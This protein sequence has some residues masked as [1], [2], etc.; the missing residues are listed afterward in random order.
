MIKKLLIITFTIVSC[1]GLAQ[2]NKFR[3]KEYSIFDSKTHKVIQENTDTD[4]LI[5]EDLDNYQ[6]VVYA[7][8]TMQLDV[9]DTF[10]K[11][12]NTGFEFI[13]IDNDGKKLNL[14]YD[15]RYWKSERIVF[16]TLFYTN[17]YIIYK[18]YPLF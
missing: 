1:L 4:I 12:D 14:I 18:S 9:I 3:A 10:E 16:I 6:F 17:V 11:K 15:L 5:T 7:N 13:C 8:K 2:V